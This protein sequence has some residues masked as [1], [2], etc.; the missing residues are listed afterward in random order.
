MP[1]SDQEIRTKVLEAI[2][3]GAVLNVENI[4]TD[5]NFRDAGLDSLD[6]VNSVFAL[7]ESFG[8]SIPS[9]Q[10]SEI[11]SVDELIALVKKLLEEENK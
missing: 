7:E 2:A 6:I 9:G 4:P 1:L 3:K 8:I 11:N 5:V 10:E